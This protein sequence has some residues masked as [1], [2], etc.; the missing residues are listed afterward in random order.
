MI[1][2]FFPLSQRTW[3]GDRRHAL[4]GLAHDNQPVRLTNAFSKK[5]ENHAAAV[6]LYVMYYNFGR[7]IWLRIGFPAPGQTRYVWLTPA[8]VVRDDP[9][10]TP[11]LSSRLLPDC[12]H[13]APPT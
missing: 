6:A 12:H 7:V 3:T 10:P 9:L 13:G 11:P 4:G 2:S 1:D 8:D 5:A